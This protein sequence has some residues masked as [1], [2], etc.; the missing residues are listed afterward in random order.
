MATKIEGKVVGII[1]D[2]HLVGPFGRRVVA[3]LRAANALV[4]EDGR[5]GRRA[6]HLLEPK[7]EPSDRASS[8]LGRSGPLVV[9][10]ILGV[11]PDAVILVLKADEALDRLRALMHARGVKEVWVA[12]PTGAFPEQEASHVVAKMLGQEPLVPATQSTQSQP[13]AAVRPARN[14]V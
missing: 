13:L 1:G 3:A 11:N 10:A 14:R 5:V 7:P 12:T 9:P 8:G 4:V 6:A 2:E